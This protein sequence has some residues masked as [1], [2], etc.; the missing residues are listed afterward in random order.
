MKNLDGFENSVVI[1]QDM[2]TSGGTD[3][4]STYKLMSSIVI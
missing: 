3:Q 4:A 1:L 2:L